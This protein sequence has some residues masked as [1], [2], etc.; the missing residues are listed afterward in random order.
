MNADMST[1]NKLKNRIQSIASERQRIAQNVSYSINH[2][3]IIQ[4]I[5][6]VAGNDEEALAL[7]DRVNSITGSRISIP[8]TKEESKA[9]FDKFPL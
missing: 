7:A 4:R 3:T 1:R 2:L 9:Q 8:S 6:F 5:Y